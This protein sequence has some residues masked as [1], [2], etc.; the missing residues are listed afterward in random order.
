MSDFRI[1]ALN[2]GERFYRALLMLYPRAFRETFALDL[3]ET[4]RDQRRDAARNGRSAA[5]FWL[6]VMLDVVAQATVGR[7]TSP[8]R[9]L[10]AARQQPPGAL[11]TM[12]FL[13]E[14]RSSELRFALRRL[15]RAPSFTITTIV[16][17][18]LG[19]GATTAVFS[20]VDGV[21]LRALP[22]P[23]SNRL[24]YLSHTVAV[25]GVGA[26][27]QS[28]GTLLAY[29]RHAT[30]LDGVAATRDIETTV[31]AN[32]GDGA[33]AERVSAAAGTSNIFDVLRVRPALGRAFLP[34]E[35]V[36]GARPVVLLSDTFWRR[37]FGGDRSV[38][39]KQLTVDGTVRE[40]IGVM[41][42][43][44]SYPEAGTQLWIPLAIDPAHVA[45]GSFNFYGVARLKPDANLESVQA[46][47]AR[48]VPDVATEFPGEVPPAMWASAG[49]RPVVQDLRD[50]MVG[51]VSRLLW[52][53]LGSVSLV[54]LIACANVANLVL[55]RSEARQL[56][57]AVR[58]A[59]GS[60]LGGVIVHSLSESLL[61]AS[62]GGVL[63]VGIATAGI[64]A[65]RT[66][67]PST[68]VPRLDELTLDPRVLLFS[69]VVAA[70]C[71]VLV[72]LVPIMRARRV[73]L[74]SALRG[75]GRNATG[76]PDRQRMRST[77]V[78]AQVSLALVLVATSGLLARSFSRLRDVQPGFDANGVVMTRVALDRAK[79][80]T[81]AAR[82]AA[83]DAMIAGVRALP[84]VTSATL[85]DWVPLSQDH[86]TS[87][88]A[89]EDQPLP[90]G[91]VPRVHALA[92][93]DPNYFATVGIPLV[94][95]RTIRVQDAAQ[96]SP[97]VVVSRA[98][99]KRYWKDGDALGRRLRPGISGPWL[100]V[101]GVAEDVHQEALDEPATD[102]VYM[103]FV[104]VEND[105]PVA[106]NSAAILVRTTAESGTMLRA[107]RK[108]V[109][110][111]DASIPSYDERTLSSVMSAA[112]ARARTTLGLLMVA[113][114]IALLLGAVGIYGVMAY[115]VTL[116]RR[117]IG[118]R[119]ALGASPRDVRR[120]IAGGGVRLAAIGVLIG[121]PCAYATSRLLRGLLYDVSPG[122]PRTLAAT[123]VVLLLT[124][125]I[126]SWIPARRA[127]AVDPADVLHD[128]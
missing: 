58:S 104:T 108:V 109:Q 83:Y 81:A 63:G 4:F 82:M 15:S 65:T 18:A 5:R 14:F 114:G 95:G 22:Y 61:L 8:Q 119:L 75:G 93:V 125:L 28:E 42:P 100:T 26:V 72:S 87:S 79:Y 107:V 77:L 6:T 64:A 57:L 126:A 46:D 44:F 49:V 60:G 66:Y 56:E 10:R 90:P 118:V 105:T 30:T 88:T 70:F 112:T 98:F 1:P 55:V 117:E 17:L 69:F 106:P 43:G 32:A 94:A 37:R 120:M 121:V 115:G 67:G 2:R 40:I 41:S 123:C 34:G 102:L 38:V 12:R 27:D 122:D 111:Y 96:P 51:D 86:N 103:P 74:A 9:Y 92:S 48:I 24:V 33:R 99:A 80:T 84:S 113:S 21:L 124:A 101:V 54:L 23:E 31:G 68:N 13:R 91:A 39:G 36:R 7:L 35:D 78:V 128:G 71:G 116:R 52:I 97:E 11:T 73:S 85:T 50:A 29:Q 76:G 45:T 19:I 3:V 62:A 110:E 20:V 59:L 53:L 127:A 16:V 89:I 47:L 25:G